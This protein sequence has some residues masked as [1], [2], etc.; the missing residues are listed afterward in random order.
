MLDG[1]GTAC[2]ASA[3]VES[4]GDGSYLTTERE[5]GNAFAANQTVN[6]SDIDEHA[7]TG[8]GAIPATT[9]S[10]DYANDSLSKLRHPIQRHRLAQLTKRWRE[11]Q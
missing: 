3:G 7:P 6:E 11:T 9:R 4:V 2:F 8:T 10:V 5:I 1:G